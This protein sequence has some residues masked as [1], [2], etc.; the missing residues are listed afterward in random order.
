M[1]KY[2]PIILSVFI[3]ILVGIWV[4]SKKNIQQTN[5]HTPSVYNIGTFGVQK[6]CAK[7]PRFLR[8]IN[9]PQP[10]IIDLSQKKYK[11]IAFHYGKNYSKVLHPK[12]WEQY[13]HFSTYTI[14]N[15]GN[16]FLVPTPFISIRPTTFNLQKNIYKLDTLTGKLSIF[17]HF[18]NV[19]PSAYNPY[20]LNT[21]TFDCEEKTLWAATIDASDYKLEKGKIHHIS[22]KQKEILETIHGIDALSLSVMKTK[23]RK[24]LLVGSAR[25]NG[26]YAYDISKK[27]NA[28]K[29]IKL[30]T[31]PV[32]NERIR[33]IKIISKDTLELQSLPFTYSLI[34]QSSQQDRTFYIA[35][36]HLLDKKWIITKK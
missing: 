17:M 5:K 12:I 11:G 16:I 22:P 21:I 30:F 34:A 36:W 14:D 1:R 27:K 23:E 20:G 15:M 25:D 6:T 4:I 29:K 19:A 8:N 9:I 28:Y 7:P 33:K 24:Y 3:I 13:E 2:L 32:A 26:L 35:K 10:V 18:E 31:L